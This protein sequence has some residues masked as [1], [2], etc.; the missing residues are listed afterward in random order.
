MSIVAH[1]LSSYIQAL[2]AIEDFVSDQVREHGV[3]ALSEGETMHWYCRYCS[4]EALGSASAIEHDDYCIT[5]K[6]KKVRELRKEL[7]QNGVV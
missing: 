6:L 3:N 4:G 1:D 2:E 7:K 5:L